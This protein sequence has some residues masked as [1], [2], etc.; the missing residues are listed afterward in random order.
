[1]Q[2]TPTH[3]QTEH[4]FIKF[5]FNL[6]Q[7]QSD[8]SKQRRVHWSGHQSRWRQAQ[9][10]TERKVTFCGV[11]SY[12]EWIVFPANLWVSCMEPFLPLR[13]LLPLV[14]GREK[15][16]WGLSLVSWLKDLGRFQQHSSTTK[17]TLKENLG[18]MC[19]NAFLELIF[20]KLGEV[21]FG[22]GSHVAKASLKIIV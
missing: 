8:M 10:K 17:W 22:I 12:N 14:L 13:V 6:P 21:L 2:Q 20:W 18:G 16:D 3:W 15:Q 1:M 7:K 4:L 5:L 19:W 11:L 9:K